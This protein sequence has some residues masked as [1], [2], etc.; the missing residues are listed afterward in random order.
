MSTPSL[1]RLFDLLPAVYRLRDAENGWQLRALLQVMARQANDVE[2][3]IGQLYENWFIETCQEWVVPYLGDLI[4]YKPGRTGID[5]P[6]PVT[7]EDQL[8]EKFVIARR[9]V[10]NTIRFRRRKG[11]LAVLAELSQAVADWP[12]RAIEFYKLLLVTQAINYLRLNR[13]RTVD[14]RDGD[15]LDLLSSHFDELGHTIDVRRPDSRHD[16][17]RF[18]ISSVG[19]FV[20]R[21]RSYPISYA[22]AYCCE[23]AGDNFYLFSALGNDTPLFTSPV[24]NPRAC[25]E[26]GL[27]NVPEPI[28]RRAFAARGADVEPGEEPGKQGYY[29]RKDSFAIYAPDWPTPGSPQPIPAEVIV[30]ANLSN[31]KYHPA[32]NFVAVDPELGRISFPARQLPKSGVW[33]Y[34]HYGFNADLGGGEYSRPIS[35]PDPST[36]YRVGATETF[37]TIA[38]ALVQWSSDKPKGAVIE[39]IDDGVYTESPTISL[40]KDQY[41]QIRAVSGKR[42]VIRLLDT[43][44]NMPDSLSVAGEEGSWFVLDGVVATGRGLALKGQLAGAA[45][46]HV[47]L[48]PGWGLQC[49]CDPVHSGEAS[50]TIEDSVTCVTIEHSIVGSI[51][52]IRDQATL[53]PVLIR[54]NDSIVDATDIDHAALSDP[55]TGL[56]YATLTILRSTVFGALQVHAIDLAENSIFEGQLCVQ[57]SQSGCIRFCYVPPGAVT[58]RRYECQ[59]DLVEAAASADVL[60][61]DP[62]ATQAQIIAAQTLADLR[63]QP[64]FNSRRYGNPAYCQLADACAAEIRTGADDE[65]EMGVF[66]DLFQPQREANLQARLDEFVPAAM[67]ASIFHAT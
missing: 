50:L 58:P 19:L 10:A 41:L 62:H 15:A 40:G 43:L 17:G 63:V 7:I 57:R 56:A 6:G 53:D 33:V 59:P 1:D 3:D 11:T 32:K 20:W 5:L 29:G 23:A 49:N 34:Y 54:V 9:E 18:S 28:R 12:A 42:P 35:Q 65:S 39:I 21:L 22:P 60:A 24:S 52:V 61:A 2:A 66:H 37:N 27:L 14:L 45:L 47:T 51:V 8:R 13:A 26:A 46:R 36:V 25:A 44:T 55:E 38:K 31:W 30:P 67:D 48:V 4:G 64:Q 16:R